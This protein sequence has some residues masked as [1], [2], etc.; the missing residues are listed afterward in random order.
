MPPQ[1][2]P[3]PIPPRLVDPV[4]ATLIVE[5]IV[6]GEPDFDFSK[7]T[8]TMQGTRDEGNTPLD[9]TL[10]DRASNIWTENSFPPGHYTVKAVVTE[11]PP[12]SSSVNAV[13][14]NGQT[15]QVTIALRRDRPSNIAMTFVI[16]FWFDKAFIEPCL[17]QVLKQVADYAQSHPDEKLVIVGH[18][19]LVGPDTYNQSLSERRA[20]SVYAG[21]THGGDRAAALAEWNALRQRAF[22][23]SPTVKDSWGTR[24]Y[25]YML[26][27]L[28]YYPGN[29]DGN[30]GPLTDAGVSAF[31][32]DNGLPKNGIVNDATWAALIDAYL[33]QDAL[34]ISVNQFL[35]NCEGEILRWLGCGEQDPI[36]NTQDAWRPNR[37][38]ELLFVKAAQLPCQVPVPVTFNLPTPGIVNNNWCL[39]TGNPNQRCCFTTRDTEQPDKWL[40]Q[41]AEPG[42]VTVR[43]SIKFEDDTPLANVKYVLIAPDG[44]NMDGERSSGA[45]RG[46]PIPGR[47]S[48]D[49]SFAYPNK[50]KGIGVYI[51]EIEGPFVAR[52][53][54][55]PPGAGKGNVVC[56]RLNGS[57]DFDVIVSPVEAGDPRRKL[58]GTIFDRLSEPRKQTQVEVVFADGSTATTTTNDSG[59]FVVEMVSPQEVGKIRYRIT[60]TDPTDVV[61]FEDFFIDVQGSNTDEGVRRRLH[62][63][64]YLTD[65]DLS[66]AVTAFQAVHGLDTTGEADLETRNKLAAVHDGN[67]LLVPEFQLSRE[68]LKPEDLD[69]EGPPL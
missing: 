68:L 56:N 2:P 53:A 12:M 11:P 69:E 13:I 63:L 6:E 49:G 9:R 14:Q 61:F 64:G 26:Q 48:A 19:D 58:R 17:R 44:E 43:G 21:L 37:R 31:Q 59:K 46:K 27:D 8:V 41:T 54:S 23:E 50:P 55:D 32:Q 40:I 47:T 38:T 30:H 29:I 42:T 67:E 45:S 5:V 7:V 1:E 57:S 65:D 25:Q 51:L 60:D 66:S 33:G 10:T 3:P 28:D 20:R 4:T 39:G 35:P 18:T 62:N 15:T 24:E 16:H 34:A 52:L 36:R 22:G